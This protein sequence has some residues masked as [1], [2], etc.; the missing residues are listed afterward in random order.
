MGKYVTSTGT[1][2]RVRIDGEAGLIRRRVSRITRNS[3]SVYVAVD[4][5][6]DV[7]PDKYA[8]ICDTHSTLVGAA[9]VADAKAFARSGEFCEY[10]MTGVRNEPRVPRD[11]PQTKE[12]FVA[13]VKGILS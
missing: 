6:I 8:V 9:T 1:G 4:Q 11:L 7:G 12:E 13:A 2:K 5:G 10:C 3:T